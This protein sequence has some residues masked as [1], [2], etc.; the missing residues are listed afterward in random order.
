M[1][2]LGWHDAEVRMTWCIISLRTL[3]SGLYLAQFYDQILV[4]QYQPSH[5]DTLFKA[6]PSLRNYEYKIG[7]HLAIL[8]DDCEAFLLITNIHCSK[9]GQYKNFMEN[10]LE[11]QQLPHYLLLQAVSCLRLPHY[12]LVGW[13]RLMRCWM[14]C[15][16]L[17]C[18]I[19][20]CY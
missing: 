11:V 20:L 12:L 14:R 2:R 19:K 5:Y 15:G 18:S 6:K 13:V 9:R 4:L 3:S 10:L 16:C 17:M 7:E 1:Q 8:T